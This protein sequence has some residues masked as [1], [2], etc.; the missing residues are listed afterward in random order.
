MGSQIASDQVLSLVLDCVKEYLEGNQEASD[1]RQ[2]EA[3]DTST[4][5]FG[6]KGL[7]DSMG[8]V[9]LLT[10]LE[11]RLEEDFG[12]EVT[13]A[14]DSTMSGTRSPFRSV[15]TLAAYIMSV[16]QEHA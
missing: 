16:A 1:D 5:L 2:V 6:A 12:I 14:S 9:I 10:D 15:S 3:L 11:E 4:K 8:V 7:L 13:L